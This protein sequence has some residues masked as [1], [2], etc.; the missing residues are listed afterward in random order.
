M[1]KLLILTIIILLFNSCEKDVSV[2]PPTTDVPITSL[3]I[4]SQ[5]QGA[6]IYENGRNTGLTTPDT[7]GWLEEKE[8]QFTLTL[9]LYRDTAFNIT[10]KKNEQLNLLID[11]HSNKKM[12]GNISCLSDPEGAQIFLNDENTG[13]TTP[14]TLRSLIPGEHKIIFKIDNCR[15]DSTFPIVL[16]NKTSTASI[17]LM[18]TTIFVDYTAGSSELNENYLDNITIDSEDVLWISSINGLH[19]FVSPNNVTNFSLDNSPLEVGN[20]IK[21]MVIDDQDNLY[22]G[23]LKGLFQTDGNYWEEY[24]DNGKTFPEDFVNDLMIDR[25]GKIWIATKQGVFFRENGQFKN[26]SDIL[27]ELQRTSVEAIDIDSRGYTWFAASDTTFIQLR[28]SSYMRWQKSLVAHKTGKDIPFDNISQ[29]THGES[30]V[31]FV[32]K[33]GLLSYSHAT[34]KWNAYMYNFP[35]NTINK[36][37]IDDEDRKWVCTKDF[38]LIMFKTNPVNSRR[39]DTETSELPSNYISDCVMDSKGNLWLT[40]YGHGVIKFKESSI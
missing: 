3:I 16:S 32:Y 17:D 6:K 29:I 25:D 2:S 35:P 15:P 9:P 1:K 8:Y 34:G 7:L 11:Y 4:N 38:G 18:D 26:I 28:G 19:K 30:D 23:T 36:I 20:I 5:P 37:F 22:L 39:Y 31:W 10:V 40:T 13:L 12:L 14:N 27:S 24:Y 33:Y 21:S